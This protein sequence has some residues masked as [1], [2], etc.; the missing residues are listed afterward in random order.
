MISFVTFPSINQSCSFNKFFSTSFSKR[1]QVPWEIRFNWQIKVGGSILSK[2]I[3][4]NWPTKLYK[5]VH[6]K[7][8]NYMK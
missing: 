4:E 5:K 1:K 7:K 6:S 3:K 8:K 2:E